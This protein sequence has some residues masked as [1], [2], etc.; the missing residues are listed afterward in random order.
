MSGEP[1]QAPPGSAPPLRAQPLAE[2]RSEA[3]LPLPER[4]VRDFEPTLEQHLGDVAKAE[5]VAQ[6]PQHGEQHDVGRV[7]EIVEWRA[8]SAR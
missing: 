7:L 4:L 1:G 3:E 5:L 2:E 6:P 8:P